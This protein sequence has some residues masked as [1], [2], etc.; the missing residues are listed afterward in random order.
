MRCC[1]RATPMNW[2]MTAWSSL[3]TSNSKQNRIYHFFRKRFNQR[4]FQSLYA[5]SYRNWLAVSCFAFWKAF[6][7][8][9]S[10]SVNGIFD[11]VRY[12]VIDDVRYD[13][14]STYG[15]VSDSVY[16]WPCWAKFSNGLVRWSIRMI[17]AK[18]YELVSKCVKVMPKMLW[19]LF[20]PDTVYNT[21]LRCKTRLKPSP[22]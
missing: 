4:R 18:N 3:A 7:K 1:D 13:V 9:P 12:D 11:D 20:F 8:C 2:T 14:I 6:V 10:L 19:P 16:C 15:C 5:Y 21:K 17:C 22:R